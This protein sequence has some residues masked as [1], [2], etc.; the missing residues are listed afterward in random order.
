MYFSLFRPFYFFTKTAHPPPPL[1]KKVSIRLFFNVILSF[2]AVRRARG[3]DWFPFDFGLPLTA[4]QGIAPPSLV[5]PDWV[6]T[7]PPPCVSS[8]S[9]AFPNGFFL[10]S[11]PAISPVKIL[12]DLPF[13]MW[14]P[15]YP[16][17]HFS[18]PFK[19]VLPAIPAVLQGTVI[20]PFSPVVPIFFLTS[21]VQ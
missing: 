11:S 2:P 4:Y 17:P 1:L 13:E 14:T 5:A 10:A 6:Y 21:F 15:L 7:H 9:L 19:D 16:A 18:C 20:H 12:V 3:P 8:C